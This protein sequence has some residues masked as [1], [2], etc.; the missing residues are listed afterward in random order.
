MVNTIS[1]TPSITG[2]TQSSRR[3]I[4]FAILSPQ[5]YGEGRGPSPAPGAVSSLGSGDGHSHDVDAAGVQAS[6]IP[7][8]VVVEHHSLS[9]ADGE[10][11]VVVKGPLLDGIVFRLAGLFVL[12]HTGRLNVL[13]K[14]GI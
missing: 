10:G 5:R 4:N 9:I 3:R 11:P 12:R 2:M 1:T 8:V 13:V 6:H 14:L 7:D